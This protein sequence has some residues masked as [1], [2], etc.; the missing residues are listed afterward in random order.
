M[1]PSLLSNNSSNKWPW[2]FIINSNS[3]WLRRQQRVQQLLLPRGCIRNNHTG[4]QNN[5][6]KTTTSTA[7]ALFQN[8]T[9]K[10]ISTAHTDEQ[11][12]DVETFFWWGGKEK[13]ALGIPRMD[14][15]RSSP[16]LIHLE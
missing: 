6:N 12:R 2:P 4:K 1:Q 5:Y 15:Q 11:R 14:G 16:M 9:N 8:Q 13:C 3:K 7:T 10:M